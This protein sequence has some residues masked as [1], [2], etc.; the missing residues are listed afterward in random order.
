VGDSARKFVAVL[1][2]LF[3]AVLV[4]ELS[5]ANPFI[6]SAWLGSRGRRLSRG[7]HSNGVGG[8]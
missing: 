7:K 5:S 3:V 8:H 6:S 2:R 1:C 4:D